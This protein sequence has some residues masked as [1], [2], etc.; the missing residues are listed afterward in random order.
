MSISFDGRVA[1]VTG[2][3][4]G[5]GRQHALALAARGAKVVINYTKNLQDA[6]DTASACRAAGG[7]AILRQA[8]VSQDDDCKKLIQT[9][10]D[11][12]GRIDG[13]FNNAGTTKIVPH[14]DPDTG[15]RAWTRDPDQ[16]GVLRFCAGPLA[17]GMAG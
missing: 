2:A 8:D 13:L 11:T 6:E 16:H 14:H 7:K 12:W 4:G 1:I 5:L 15:P 10:L 3:G 17:A 9:T